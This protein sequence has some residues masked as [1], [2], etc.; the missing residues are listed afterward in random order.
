MDEAVL[1]ERAP[2][3]QI[4]FQLE[5]HPVRFAGMSTWRSRDISA[6]DLVLYGN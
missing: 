4:L 2:L 3:P 1:R 6:P 5:S